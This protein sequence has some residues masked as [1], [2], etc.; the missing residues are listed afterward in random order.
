L[1]SRDHAG[2]R[3]TSF[4]HGQHLTNVT[5]QGQGRRSVIDGNG[6]DWWDRHQNKTEVFTR[7]HLVEFLYST[8]ISMKDLTL[9]NSPFWTSHFYD[10]DGVHVKGVHI[11]NPP[12]SPN[13]DGWDPDSSRNVLIEDSSYVGGDDCVAI[14][15]GWDCFGVDYGRP[16]VNITV[17]NL[18]CHGIFAGIAIGSEMSGGVQNVTIENIRFT[19]ANKPVNIKGKCCSC[20]IL[21]ARCRPTILQTTLIYVPFVI[22]GNTRGGYVADVVYRNLTI[23]GNVDQAIHVDGF[24]YYNNPNPECPSDWMPSRPV[25]VE[26]VSFQNIDGRQ[27][28]I[29]GKEVYHFAGL[30]NSAFQD[31]LMENVYFSKPPHAVGWNCTNLVN[32]TVRGSSVLPW[33]PCGLFQITGDDGSQR[34]TQVGAGVRE[35]IHVVI[36]AL[37]L[38]MVLLRVRSIRKKSSSSTP[39]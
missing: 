26:R 6:K 20:G 15:S 16:A 38:L 31:L 24:H 39:T 18:T 3:F 22:V 10:C 17:R 29:Q 13:T 4:L 37:S 32:A 5:V 1:V 34:S 28:V 23:Y 35:Y 33:P 11:R 27:A 8:D 25:K 36:V 2:P 19:R 9:R 7:G 12:D 14:K 30:P 21:R